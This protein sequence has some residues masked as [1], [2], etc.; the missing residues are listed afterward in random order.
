M[1]DEIKAGKI[2]KDLL[3]RA[4]FPD[5]CERRDREERKRLYRCNHKLQKCTACGEF[6]KCIKDYIGGGS[7]YYFYICRSCNLKFEFSTYNFK[8]EKF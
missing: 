1:V 5:M 7:H 8:L 4:A 2:L 6:L 3:I